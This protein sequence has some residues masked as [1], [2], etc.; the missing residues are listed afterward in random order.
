MMN[1]SPFYVVE[2]FIS[3]LM[4]EDI[5]DIVDFNVPDQ[6]KDGKYVK[7]TKRSE[8]AEG[9]IY[10]RL[11]MLLPEIQGHYQM[12]Y[13]GTESV[14]FEWF[15]AGS[16]GTFRAENS[17]HLRGKWVRTNARD[18]TAVLFLS[19]Y[20]ENTPFEQEFDVYGGKLEFVQHHFGFNP[21]RGTLIVFPS[22][23]HFINNTTEVFAGDLFQARFHIVA[24]TPYMY[25]PGSFPGNYT[26]WFGPY[27]NQPS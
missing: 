20:Q 19:D 12:L 4:C 15:P 11:L 23:P 21:Q 10:E 8:T 18:L 2:E 6:N 27:L 5:V 1:K 9:L 13:R 7:T 16:S 22:D 3:P 14:E 26:T 25:N 24:K 17:E